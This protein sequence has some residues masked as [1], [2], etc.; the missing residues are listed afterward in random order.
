MAIAFDAVASATAA[1]NVASGSS[2]QTWSHT[3][4]GSDRILL[5]WLTANGGN[6]N[7]WSV[8]YN[9][10]SMTAV[11]VGPTQQSRLFALLNPASG[12]NTVSV[13]HD[14][15]TATLIGNSISYTGV[16]T[17]T[18]FVAGTSGTGTNPTVTI[19]SATDSVVVD[20]LF[21]RA[22]ITSTNQTTTQRSKLSNGN[23][24]QAIGEKAGAASTVM[25]WTVVAS[26]DTN[27]DVGVSLTPT[28]GPTITSQPTAQT[29]RLNGDATT[30]ATFSVT[31]T[32]TGG[33]TYDWELETTVGGGSY[34]NLADGNGATWTGQAAASCVGTFTAT[35]LSGRRVRCNVTDSNG[36]TTTSA[37]TL[38]VLNGPTL[39]STSG[40]VTNGTE[41]FTVLSDDPLTANGEVLLV[42]STFRNVTRRTTVR[43]LT[44]VAAAESSLTSSVF[45]LTANG[46]SQA[47]LTATFKDED[48]VGMG[49]L[50][51]TYA[52]ER[53]IL[54]SNECFVSSDKTDIDSDG[55]DSATISIQLKRI[56]NGEYVP[57]P[58]YTAASNVTIAVSGTNNT[59]TQPTGSADESG[60]CTGS[61]V[62]TQAAATKTV[63]V[64]AF[65]IVLPT[66]TVTTDGGYVPPTPGDPFFE[67]DFAGTQK[68]NAN[69]FTWNTTGSR[70]SVVSFDGY[71]ALRFRFG[72]DATGADSSAEQ[73]FN[74][75]VEVPHLWLQYDL[76]V[77]SNFAHRNDSPTNNKF[78]LFWRDVYSDVAGGTWRCGWEYQLSGGN[79]V[80]RAYSSRWNFNSQSDANPN[81]D[82]APTGN[83]STLISGSGPITTNAWNQIRIELAAASNSTATDGIQR[84][85]VNGTLVLEI[86]TGKFWNYETGST[87]ADCYLQN[88]YFMGWANSGF[89]D[90]T[91][92]HIKA[93]KFYN[94]DPAW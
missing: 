41:T 45:A 42:S 52:V 39:S 60:V 67:D 38:T 68:N 5:V 72:P 12:T 18:G 37:V 34:A 77:P 71:N 54:A 9:G 2:P 48:A 63:T 14:A 73:R 89:T 29:A 31:A 66:I 47:T 84:M 62:T 1:L 15:T 35:T 70:V 43:P 78:A 94:T 8:T 6:K 27:Y 50:G 33:L 13:T 11:G 93:V 49:G 23:A 76:H 58:N 57:L 3:C 51:V 92:F 82:Y 90:Q 10:V 24:G 44:A 22:S 55:V 87:P 88:G 64:T 86:T 40:T 74:M 61:F 20:F 75:G 81:G 59:I 19:T 26:G 30:T 83:G 85:W 16:S 79:S 80:S 4:T 36:T 25:G 28:V 69:G 17:Y 32:G 56:I 91:D 46:S 53:F 21:S 65:G 7:N